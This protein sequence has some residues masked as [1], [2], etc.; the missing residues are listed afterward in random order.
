MICFSCA[1]SSASA[2]C[3]AIFNASSIASGPAFTRS[4]SVSPETN[5]ITRQV[6][7]DAGM[8]LTK[9]L[10]VRRRILGEEHPD[11]LAATMN[12]TSIYQFEGRYANAEALLTGVLEVQRR[13]LGE[14][15]PDTLTTIS[16]LGGLYRLQKKYGEVEKLPTEALETR[17]QVLGGEHPAH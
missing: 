7:A 1:A 12:L 17:Q 9:I 11:T 6:Y 16:N 2:I 8:L 14:E 10:G 5:S 15:R 13:V 4:A 3:I